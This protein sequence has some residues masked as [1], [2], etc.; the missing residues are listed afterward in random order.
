MDQPN[1]E[2]ILEKYGIGPT[3]CW[4]NCPV[5]WE[6]LVEDLIQNLV[7]IGWDKKLGQVKDKFGGLRFYVDGELTKQMRDMIDEA[8]AAS[9]NICQ[10]CGASP[11]RGVS[12]RTKCAACA[13]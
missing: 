5:G 8:E 1:V 12:W 13:R 11:A 4:S 3:P 10:D 9:F 2:R 7:A 6:P